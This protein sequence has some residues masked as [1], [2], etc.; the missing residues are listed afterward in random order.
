MIAEFLGGIATNS[1][2]I[3]FQTTPKITNELESAAG[4]HKEGILKG[5]VLEE[6][7][8]RW[9]IHSILAISSYLLPL[10]FVVITEIVI[11][12]AFNSIYGL[13]FIP[14]IL[15]FAC[16]SPHLIANCQAL[17]PFTFAHPIPVLIYMVLLVLGYSSFMCMLLE[18]I[19]VLAYF[20]VL[21]KGNETLFIH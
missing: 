12:F 11:T 19:L 1:G 18:S 15:L 6:L 20:S 10:C 7:V 13:S 4:L 9:L 17:L 8:R 21:Y 5:I 14:V 3:R 2:N 16:C